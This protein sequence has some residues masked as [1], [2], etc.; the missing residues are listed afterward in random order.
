MPLKLNTLGY[1]ANVLN[2]GS[3]QVLQVTQL[4]GLILVEL[5]A[6]NEMYAS[7][8]NQMDE[9]ESIRA[10]STYAAST[11]LTNPT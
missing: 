2:D 10:D 4:L 11:S 5:R 3:L 6:L 8:N 9:L 7:A 1:P